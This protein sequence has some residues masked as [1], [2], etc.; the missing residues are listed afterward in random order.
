ME[1]DIVHSVGKGEDGANRFGHGIA[2][3]VLHRCRDVTNHV[4]Y[5]LN[6]SVSENED[7]SSHFVVFGKSM[8][9]FFGDPSPRDTKQV[10]VVWRQEGING[11]FRVCVGENEDLK[12]SCICVGTKCQ[13]Y[14]TAKDDC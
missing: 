3:T 5:L 4:R 13:H 14:M 11:T 1:R 8:N 6:L 9:V 7:A 10:V 12:V 2:P